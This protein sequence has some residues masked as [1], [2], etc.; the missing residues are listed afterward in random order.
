MKKLKAYENFYKLLFVCSFLLQ[1]QTESLQMSSLV[2]STF[3]YLFF[4]GNVSST[5]NQFW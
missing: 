1:L 3:I 4:K 2:K 5:V